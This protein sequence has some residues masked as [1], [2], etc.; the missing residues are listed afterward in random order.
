M[1]VWYRK[2]KLHNIVNKTIKDRKS[3]YGYTCAAKGVDRD[4]ALCSGYITGCVIDGKI[5][6][7]Q[8]KIMKTVIALEKKMYF[9]MNT[10][11]I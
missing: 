6:M 2:S 3:G 11:L 7:P 1:L 4:R 8:R 10:L 5:C 9:F